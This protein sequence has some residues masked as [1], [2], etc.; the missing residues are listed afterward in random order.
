[1]AAVTSPRY[2]AIDRVEGN[3]HQSSGRRI[4]LTVDL[5][6]L[7]LEANECCDPITGVDRRARTKGLTCEESDIRKAVCQ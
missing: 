1:M 3:L 6:S 7:N 2:S 5:G 4:V